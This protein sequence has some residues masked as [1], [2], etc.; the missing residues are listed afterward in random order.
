MKINAYI[1]I[2]EIQEL[3][4]TLYKDNDNLSFYQS[5]EWNSCLEK[6][7]HASKMLRYR[8]CQ[9]V[10]YAFDGQVILPLII[11]SKN[12]IIS[13][14]GHKESSDYLSFIF[15]NLDDNL[16]QKILNFLLI[17]YENF[18]LYFDKIN[19]SNILCEMLQKV[20]TLQN[21]NVKSEKKECV[22]IPLNADMDSFYR[23]LSKNAR[24]NYRTA[25]NRLKR[26]QHSYQVRTNVIKLDDLQ[27]G[28]F[29]KL[30]RERRD[31]CDKREI[32]IKKIRH[33]AKKMISFIPGFSVIDPLTLYSLQVP[34][35]LSSIFVD[36]ELAAFCEGNYNN[37]K[38]TISIARIATN[39]VYYS[40]SPG[41]ILLIETLEQLKDQIH[42]FD[43]TRGV[44]DYKFKLNGKKHYNYSFLLQRH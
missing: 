30:Y 3:W 40:Y 16:L 26:D 11:D 27:A 36:N 20:K 17:K 37:R 9:L 15:K 31:Y 10:Y 13:L 7:F 42:F 4:R 24:Q 14:L 25:K 35:F 8:G 1:H 22:Y 43:L 41:Q 12:K 38:G 23:S 5:Y 6:Q 29:Y 39:E 19:E 21:C 44:E 2:K 18:C 32:F 33:S 34:V 28:T